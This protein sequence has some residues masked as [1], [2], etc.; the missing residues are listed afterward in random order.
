MAIFIVS[1]ILQLLVAGV[2]VAVL[3]T[4]LSR[5]SG[6]D[7]GRAL[8]R[9]FRYG[10]LLVLTVLV[11]TGV[12]GLISLADPEVTAGPGYSAFMLAC[13]IV[14]G[15]GLLL[16]LRWVRRALERSGGADRGWEIYLV[17]A[18]LASL[19]TAA[20]GT[21]IWGE[22]LTEGMF[23]ITP[24]AVMV[25]WG[26]IWLLH[27][28]LAGRRGRGGHLRYGVLLGSAAGL[29]TGSVFAVL[30]VQGVLGR[31]YDIVAGT[32]VIADSAEPIPS[33]LVGLVIWGAVWLRYWWSIGRREETTVLWRAYV[34]IVGVVGGLLATLT[35][36][37]Q[38]AYRILDWIVGDSTDPAALHFEELPLAVALTAVGGVVWGYHRVVLRSAAPEERGE[39][40]RV[41]RYTVTGVGLI[42]TVGGLGAVI[43]ACIQ[44][45]LPADLLY[46][47][48]RSGLVAAVTVLL[49]GAPLWW[50]YWAAVQEWRVA[51]PEAEL[52]SPTRRIYLICVFGVGGILALGSLFFLA[53]RI[54]ESFLA[55]EAGTATVFAIRWPLALALTVGVAAAYHRAVRR[56]DL[57]DTPEEPP[58]TAVGSVVLVGSGGRTV[59][60]AVEKQTGAKVRVWDRTDTGVG[61]STEAVLEVIE[62]AE[63]ER[64]LIVARPDGPEVIPYTE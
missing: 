27:H 20:T 17:V 54:L 28:T 38:L 49:V 35:G 5:R 23:R 6:R 61:F 32:T 43:A 58:R 63:H 19:V 2:A 21:Y 1:V 42:A 31:L 9:L 34:L 3:I 22:S 59:A 51:D 25:V 56:A 60:E 18:E 11:G 24:A 13:V 53:Y 37:W 7:T 12:T 29:V 8:R 64:L 40:D 44:A 36:V 48:D 10:I 55:G 14:G 39:V 41:H 30:F 4:F 16:V 50:R 62:S 46:R 33:S 15:P 26:F 52:R 47:S 57:V 45:L